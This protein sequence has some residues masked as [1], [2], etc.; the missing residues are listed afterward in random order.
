V[1]Y[2]PA[3]M[4]DIPAILGIVTR[5]VEGTAFRPPTE[6]KMRRL[7]AMGT[8]YTEGVWNGEHLVG[9]MCGNLSETFLN[10][11]VNAYDKGFYVVPEHRGGTIAVRLLRN[12]ERWARSNGAANVWICQSVA[13]EIDATRH[14]FERL[15]YECQGFNMRKKL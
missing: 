10:D 4:A 1:I 3:D 11:E 5:M 2:R 14:Y 8:Y 13:H 12:F 7:V 15:G 9:F 6:A